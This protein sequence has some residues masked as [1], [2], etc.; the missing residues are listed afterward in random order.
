LP[1][2][3]QAGGVQ[4]Q[5]AQATFT[6]TGQSLNFKRVIS[7]AANLPIDQ[8]ILPSGTYSIEL[9]DGW[10]LQ[11][12]GPGDPNFSPVDAEL[13]SANPVSFTVTRAQT[14]DV[15]FAFISRGVPIK[16]NDGRANV[17]I[18]VS[19]CAGYNPITGTLAG[20]TLDCLG[21]IDQN[22]YLVDD[23]GFLAR[24]F[25]EC[26]PNQLTY[27][28]LDEID[29]LL[30]LQHT[31]DREP[32]PSFLTDNPLAFAQD[33]MAGQWAQWR[34]TFDASGTTSCPTWTK[35]AVANPPT[36][37]TFQRK[38]A[39]GEPKLPFTDN[40]TTPGIL[41][42][43]KIDSLYTVAFGNA[44]STDQQCGSPG[45]CAALCAGGLPGLLVSNDDGSVTTDPPAWNDPT[46]FTPNPDPYQPPYYHPM[47][48]YGP[49]PGALFGAVE[50][51]LEGPEE[52]S[53]TEQC[54]VYV[55]GQHQL[56]TLIKNCRLRADGVTQYACVSVC[57]PPTALQ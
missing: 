45:N 7:P 42:A 15:V 23:A 17:R 18:S 55:S 38:I 25:T 22:S 39:A 44:P 10:Q 49:L 1:L 12:K 40:G 27:N 9:A 50:R 47:S 53:P 19:D 35:Q 21:T 3:A 28:P 11:A 43:V 8:E 51:A 48:F 52:M 4:Y 36:V 30:G 26:V 57:T 20:F 41:S 54:S 13:A 34:E 14:V 37:A 33:C 46:D 16:L 6:I 32:L 56:G 2:T 5:L 31:E 29:A 24:N